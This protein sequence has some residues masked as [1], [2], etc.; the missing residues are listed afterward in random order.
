MSQDAL[1]LTRSFHV[2]LA[3]SEEAFTVYVVLMSFA[4]PPVPVR[5]QRVRRAV[6]GDQLDPEVTD[7]AV[8]DVHVDGQGR[9]ALPETPVTVTGDSTVALSRMV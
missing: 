1:S 8:D 2:P 4:L 6:R 7:V 5:L 3:V 9:G